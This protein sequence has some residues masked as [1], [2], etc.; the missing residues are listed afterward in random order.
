M[1]QAR[2]GAA[3]EPRR[4]GGALTNNPPRPFDPR[5]RP[6]ATMAA[7]KRA[8]VRRWP[9]AT[10]S[11]PPR[12]GCSSRTAHTSNTGTPPS[13]TRSARPGSS[14]RAIDVARR[15]EPHAAAGGGRR[16]SGDR[17]AAT[18]SVTGDIRGSSR[19][20]RRRRVVV[21]IVPR[22]EARRTRGA[23][24]SRATPTWWSSRRRRRRL[25]GVRLLAVGRARAARRAPRRDGPPRG[26][27]A[28]RSGAAARAPT[29]SELLAILGAEHEHRPPG[30]LERRAVGVVVARPLARRHLA[31]QLAHARD[32]DERERHRGPPRASSRPWRTR[33]SACSRRRPRSDGPPHCSAPRQPL[34]RV[35]LEQPPGQDGALDLEPLLAVA[36]L[37]HGELRRSARARAVRTGR[38]PPARRFGGRRRPW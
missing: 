5:A 6:S 19:C 32:L 27:A 7:A 21:L 29:S 22:L 24:R 37:H 20:V 35:L 23:A 12:S 9:D 17:C 4:G 31:R 3:A 8:G 34:P 30:F 26:R 2:G 18:T 14:S 1:A 28:R 11:N 36:H 10:P 15:S 13:R 38:R 33:A 16:A 25:V